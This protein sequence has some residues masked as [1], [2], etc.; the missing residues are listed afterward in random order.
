MASRSDGFGAVISEWFNRCVEGVR[1]PDISLLAGLRSAAKSSAHSGS[2]CHMNAKSRGR[3][4]LPAFLFTPHFLSLPLSHSSHLTTTTTPIPTQHKTTTAAMADN[5][6]RLVQSL[7]QEIYDQA[8]DLTFT[9]CAS[10]SEVHINRSYYSFNDSKNFPNMP[11]YP[12]PPATCSPPGTTAPNTSAAPTPELCATGFSSCQ[13]STSSCWV[14]SP[15]TSTSQSSAAMCSGE[16]NR[17][18]VSLIVS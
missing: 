2:R 7:P 14:P 10:K 3:S 5:L 18:C 8:F 4:F 17:E 11:T 6:P 9:P 1:T 12:A 15:I 16:R 13:K